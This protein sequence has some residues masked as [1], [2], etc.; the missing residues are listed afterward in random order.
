MYQQHLFA[1]SKCCCLLQLKCPV[2]L[3]SVIHP[4]Y[5]PVSARSPDSKM[6]LGQVFSSIWH[7]SAKRTWAGL[8]LSNGPIPEQ[9][10]IMDQSQSWPSTVI[11]AMMCGADLAQIRDSYF[12][13]GAHLTLVCDSYLGYQTIK[14]QTPTQ[15][16]NFQNSFLFNK[17]E[18][19]TAW[20]TICRRESR[21]TKHKN[22][23]K[24]KTINWEKNHM[25]K[26]QC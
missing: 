21:C 1:I 4:H 10:G 5:H 7:K 8:I 26:D 13:S 20:A 6:Y 23:I 19:A 16:C 22:K 24:T 2:V 18:N 25:F 14:A 12:T 11:N 9:V 3:V 15:I 17:K